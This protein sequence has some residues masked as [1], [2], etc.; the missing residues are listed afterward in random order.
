MDIQEKKTGLSVDLGD[1]ETRKQLEALAKADGG[2][3]YGAVVR[4]LIRQEYK[5]RLARDL[6]DNPPVVN[7]MSESEMKQ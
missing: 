4:K 3:S 5:R 7:W 2:C 1:V 6:S